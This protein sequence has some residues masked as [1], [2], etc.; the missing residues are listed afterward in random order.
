M[1]VE[2]D[3]PEALSDYDRALDLARDSSD[4][5]ACRGMSLYRLGKPRQTLSELTSLLQ[6]CPDHQRA[7]RYRA[8]LR[9][10]LDDLPGCIEDYRRAV[11]LESDE[12]LVFQLEEAEEELYSRRFRT[13]DSRGQHKAAAGR[14]R[15][16]RTHDAR[17][18]RPRS[19]D[20]GQ[21]SEEPRSGLRVGRALFADPASH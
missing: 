15:G 5:R 8:R 10:S 3:D 4:I 21:C 20:Q 17:R 13:P 12:D 2:D 16:A 14:P 9:R 19:K 1:K 7:L 11:E 6:Q 18:H